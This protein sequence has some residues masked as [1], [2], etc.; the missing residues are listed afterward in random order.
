VD[1]VLEFGPNDPVFISTPRREEEDQQVPPI[2]VDL[3]SSVSDQGGENGEIGIE[4]KIKDAKLVNQTPK[5]S[6]GEGV[7]ESK[8]FCRSQNGRDSMKTDVACRADD[9]ARAAV[10]VSN[11]RATTTKASFHV[12]SPPRFAHSSRD[13]T[14][15]SRAGAKTQRPI[16]KTIAFQRGAVQSGRQSLPAR[17]KECLVTEVDDDSPPN[18]G[19]KE[20]R[21]IDNDGRRSSAEHSITAKPIRAGMSQQSAA[22]RPDSVTEDRNNHPG[23]LY[24]RHTKESFRL[25]ALQKHPSASSDLSDDQS[26]RA[27]LMP[28]V[29]PVI[30]ARKSVGLK[31][32]SDEQVAAIRGFMAPATT[33]TAAESAGRNSRRNSLKQ[34]KKTW[35]TKECSVMLA[36]HQELWKGFCPI[37]S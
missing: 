26:R 32:V 21:F 14:T 16:L 19:R 27:Q 5:P 7:I 20:V 28:Q 36:R 18:V 1:N 29:S 4:E 30:S 24:S 35:K 15:Y 23:L 37:Y 6:T 3:A 34:L 17:S 2:L 10:G 13:I 31:M 12:S 25:A 33:T 22:L 8:K 11:P 9:A